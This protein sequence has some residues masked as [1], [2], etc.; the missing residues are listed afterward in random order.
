MRFKIKTN[1]CIFGLTSMVVLAQP[2][3][4][5]LVLC[6]KHFSL[7]IPQILDPS[8]LLWLM[9]LSKYWVETTEEPK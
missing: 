6:A 4:W 7:A 2:H 5:Q 3:K 1:V 9:L 8:Q